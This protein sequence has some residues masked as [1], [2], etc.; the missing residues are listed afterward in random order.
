MSVIANGLG[1]GFSAFGMPC[2]WFLALSYKTVFLIN[3]DEHA[4]F[5]ANEY[6]NANYYW[7]SL[8]LLAEKAVCST[9]FSKCEFTIVS[10]LR[11]FSMKYFM[12]SLNEHEK[13][14]LTRLYLR[15]CFAWPLFA[16]HLFCFYWLRKA[17]LRECDVSLRTPFM[18]GLL[19]IFET[20]AS[21]GQTLQ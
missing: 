20:W 21:A 18:F 19:R 3:S 13:C 2:V 14:F 11:L 5:S 15:I 7:H 9:L 17:M 1:F 6:G 4:I 8:Y 10:N 16:S 12:L